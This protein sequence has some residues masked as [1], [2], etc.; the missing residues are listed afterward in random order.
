MK[1][2]AESKTNKN[3]KSLNHVYIVHQIQSGLI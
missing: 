2:T 1:N 3:L